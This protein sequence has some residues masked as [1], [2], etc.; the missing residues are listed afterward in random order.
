M[1]IL[2]NKH[3]EDA[4]KHIQVFV[5][6]YNSNKELLAVENKKLKEISISYETISRHV[7]DVD[8]SDLSLHLKNKKTEVYSLSQKQSEL[9]GELKS[10]KSD[11][12]T[13]LKKLH[14]LYNLLDKQNDF[15]EDSEPDTFIVEMSKLLYPNNIDN[16]Q[17]RQDPP[18]G[19]IYKSKIG[20]VSASNAAVVDGF[21]AVEP[22]IKTINLG[23]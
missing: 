14:E 2:N 22:E 17:L 10:I 9:A 23:K 1:N 5:E 7:T 15:V 11:C 4:L 20:I 19:G 13:S 18:I 16:Q 6:K 8:M 3:Y 21:A 12:L